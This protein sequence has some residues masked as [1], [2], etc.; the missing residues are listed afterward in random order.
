M[1]EFRN[2]FDGFEQIAAGYR[3]QAHSG[4]NG[5]GETICHSVRDWYN[6]DE[7]DCEQSWANHL[8]SESLNLLLTVE[9][10]LNGDDTQYTLEVQCHTSYING[11][12][13]QFIEQYHELSDDDD[14]LD[15]LDEYYSDA[16]PEKSKQ[17]INIL[18]CVIKRLN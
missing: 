17:H 6:A 3:V 15:Y 18:K 1:N 16:T 14:F 9:D 13:K 8:D 10:I 4:P 2:A 11:Q 5:Q 12:F 7:I